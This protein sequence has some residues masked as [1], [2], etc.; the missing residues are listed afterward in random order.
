MRWGRR[1]NSKNGR[2]LDATDTALSGR[3]WFDPGSRGFA[4]K[5]SSRA[6]VLT[7]FDWQATVS[8]GTR[9]L[10]L[11][12]TSLAFPSALH[13]SQTSVRGNLRNSISTKQS[14]VPGNMT[15]SAPPRHISCP[16]ISFVSQNSPLRGLHSCRGM[17]TAAMSS[18]PLSPPRRR[19]G[20]SNGRMRQTPNPTTSSLGL[21]TPSGTLLWRCLETLSTLPA[22]WIASVSRKLL[23]GSYTCVPLT[24]RSNTP[25]SMGLFGQPPRPGKLRSPDALAFWLRVARERVAS[26][27]TIGVRRSRED[28]RLSVPL[29]L[30]PSVRCL[31]QL[32]CSYGARWCCLFRER[33]EGPYASFELAKRTA[34][35]K[36]STAERSADVVTSATPLPWSGDAQGQV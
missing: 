13:T 29:S 5:I 8:H 34:I 30:P 32:Q 28:F 6:R 22:S 1:C 25:R 31:S 33:S 21:L 9:D 14:P 17:S 10:E 24:K 11:R 19:S 20:L 36:R 27:R 35:S 3:R 2:Q 15:S 4:N 12:A 18:A 26:V 7:T 23:L 16:G